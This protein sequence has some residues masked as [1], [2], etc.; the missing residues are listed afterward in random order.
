MANLNKRAAM[1][2]AG[3]L[4][5]LPLAAVADPVTVITRSTGTADVDPLVL[6]QLG[7]DGAT[8]ADELPYELT[9][10]STFDPVAS[11]PGRG[12]WAI[13]SHSEVVIDFRIG[14][15]TYHYAG[16]A[17][18]NALLYTPFT[19]GDGYQHEVLLP[20]VHFRQLALG[21]SGSFGT[22][23][24]LGTRDIAN[25]TGG[26]FDIATFPSNP[27]APGMWVMGGTAATFSVQVVSAVPEPA[28]Y[29]LLAAG[30]FVLGVGMKKG[31]L[32]R[33]CRITA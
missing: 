24:A 5:A 29:A 15:M 1:V 12:E 27:D 10:R 17:S 23:G 25:I 13:D 30:L 8:Q 11:L 33:P 32:G 19:G 14:G 3:L 18:G 6:S 9:M 7:L 16:I 4:S 21:P 28:S 22:G 20:T 31:A 26:Y 2:F